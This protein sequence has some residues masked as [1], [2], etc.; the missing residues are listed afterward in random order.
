[1]IC[2]DHAHIFASDMDKTIEFYTN[3]FGARVVYDAKLVG[4]RNVRLVLGGMGLHIYDQ[5]P[6]SADRGLVHHLGIRTD[7]LDSLVESMGSKGVQFRKPITEDEA[8]RYIMCEA[9]DG[10]LIELYEIKP[11]GE[12]MVDGAD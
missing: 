11:G 8:F 9:P 4:Q 7:E 10:V 12:W 3:M 2:F 1:M 5:Q 6:R